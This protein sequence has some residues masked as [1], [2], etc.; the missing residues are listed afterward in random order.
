MGIFVPVVVDARP[1]G[2]ARRRPGAWCSSGSGG[3][4]GAAD[5]TTRTM[6]DL[7]VLVCREFGAPEDLVH[8]RAKQNDSNPFILFHSV[9]M[10]I[11]VNIRAQQQLV[12]DEFTRDVEPSRD[13]LRVGRVVRRVRGPP[14][15]PRACRSTKRADQRC[16]RR[17]C[18]HAASPRCERSR[19]PHPPKR[20][21]R[22]RH[23]LSGAAGV[24]DLRSTAAWLSVKRSAREA[25]RR[26]ERG[27]HA[28]TSVVLD[29]LLGR[30]LRL[31]Q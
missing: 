19:F 27:K 26:N 25:K 5:W 6:R 11:F 9:A 21:D 30:A 31:E 7:Q 8:V 10:A 28:A 12:H 24:A 18:T 17:C 15:T 16:P 22:L 2:R 14:A 29:A 23:R 1:L 13:F 3:P 4:R 20:R